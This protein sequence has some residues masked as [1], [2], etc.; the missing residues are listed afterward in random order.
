M[1][2]SRRHIV[3]EEEEKVENWERARGGSA[4][5]GGEEEAQLKG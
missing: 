5:T 1:L 2:E 4:A 3:G